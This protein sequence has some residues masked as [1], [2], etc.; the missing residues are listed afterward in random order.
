[1]RILYIIHLKKDFP[2]KM[3]QIDVFFEMKF[4][5]NPINKK[6]LAKWH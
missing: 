6:K 1:M 5:E 2:Q 3:V 4:K